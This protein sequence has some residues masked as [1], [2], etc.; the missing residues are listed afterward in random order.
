M[1]KISLAFLSLVFYSSSLF[2]QVAEITDA[3][4]KFYSHFL[5]NDFVVQRNTESLSDQD[6]EFAKRK[7][8][9]VP[10]ELF[11]DFELKNETSYRIENNLKEFRFSDQPKPTL[12]TKNRIVFIFDKMAAVSRIG[13]TKDGKQALIFRSDLYEATY[14]G[15]MGLYWLVEKNGKW[16]IKQIYSPWIH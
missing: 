8:K 10:K 13:F 6:L 11:R 9:K 16:K 5:T 2:G 7:M 15:S 3:E 4:Y 14:D 1:R 12:Y